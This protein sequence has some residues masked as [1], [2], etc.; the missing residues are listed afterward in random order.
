VNSYHGM[1]MGSLAVTGDVSKRNS[2]GVPLHY[3]LPMLFDQ[4]LGAS[5]DS[6]DFFETLLEKPGNGLGLPAAIIVETIQAEG[7]VKVASR[8]WLQHLEQIAKRWEI[9]LIV[10]DIQVGCGRTGDFFSFE[11]AGICPHLVCLSKSISGYGLPMSLVLIRPDLD[12][13]SPGEHTG[14][15]RGNNLAFVAASEA[16]CYWENDIFSTEIKEKGEIAVDSL[17]RIARKYPEAQACI[18]GRGLIQG[19][20]CET[21]GL[22][23]KVS[24]DAFDRGLLIETCGPN[25]EVLKL[26]PPLT[27][28]KAELDQ[29]IRVIEE[30]MHSALERAVEATALAG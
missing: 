2:A 22:A 3:T 28:S 11:A 26:L 12:I 29:G 20:C 15:F 30:S 9:V 17:E 16:L 8:E 19:L 27:L 6:L 24:K 1:S 10:D 4:D 7:G 23:E 25:N 14:T 21:E 18:R 13:W 5:Q